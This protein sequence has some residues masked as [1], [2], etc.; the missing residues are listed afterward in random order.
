MLLYVSTFALCAIACVVLQVISFKRQQQPQQ[1]TPVS[2]SPSSSAAQATP[3]TKEDGSSAADACARM[4]RSYLVVYTLAT[5]ADWLKG[6]YVYALY[7]KY[8]Y[9]SSQISFLFV[10]GFFSSLFCGTISAAV[11]D[12]YGRKRMCLVYAF[13]YI[14][15][16]LSKLSP[17]YTILII[18][19]LLAGVATSLLFTSFEAWVAS[20]HRAREYP[21]HLLPVLFS[22]AVV[23]NGVSAILAG[24]LSQLVVSYTGLG[25][26]GPFLLAIPCLALQAFVVST[27]W[28]E[29]YGHQ[30]H[31]AITAGPLAA[32][33]NGFNAIR[34]QR[35]YLYLGLS[36][37]MFEGA[38]YVFVFLWTPTV[39]PPQVPGARPPPYGLIF[40]GFMVCIMLGGSVFG[41][42]PQQHSGGGSVFSL[43]T[44]IHTAAASV[45]AIVAACIYLG[46]YPLSWTQSVTSAD[47]SYIS[48][49]VYE[50]IVGVFYP[51]YSSIR[52]VHLADDTRAAVMSLFRVP[53]NLFVV[54]FL[55]FGGNVSLGAGFLA[56]ATV[57]ALGGFFYHKF[58]G[59]IRDVKDSTS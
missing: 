34:Q 31:S 59:E 42:L 27:T 22:R 23:C 4:H 54:V 52:S 12:A 20:E 1:Q 3:T 13:V 38:M 45:M 49:L 17:N 29:N 16:A 56:L 46:P 6:P 35:S 48:F 25:F 2:I 19:R 21:A 10:C 5:F 47:I 14:L 15:S 8:G 37:G 24:L 9:N 55:F 30:Q 57:H 50:A 40:A 39:T 58:L 11:S 18:G 43:P 28:T 51:T 36:Q 33:R 53:L 7:E 32:I 44:S 26:V 41:L